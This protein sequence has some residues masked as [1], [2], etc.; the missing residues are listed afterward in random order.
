MD[1]RRIKNLIT[2]VSKPTHKYIAE[3]TFLG[4]EKSGEIVEKELESYSFT[5]YNEEGNTLNYFQKSKNT[6]ISNHKIKENGD[7]NDSNT[8]FLKYSYKYNSKGQIVEENTY[9]SN[10]L[11]IQKSIYEYNVK[12][13]IEECRE[14]DIEGKLISSKRYD[15]KGNIIER[16]IYDR[17]GKLNRKELFKYEFDKNTVEK[18]TYDSE[19]NFKKKEIYK[20]N[21]K[22]NVIEYNSFNLEEMFDWKCITS[23][24]EYDQRNNWIKRIINDGEN[25]K[26]TTRKIVYYGEEENT[27]FPNWD[28]PFFK[29]LKE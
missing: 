17:K 10:G 21:S 7:E 2:S 24:Y 8:N 27:D 1:N 29:D 22:G 19:R 25:Y 12:G 11:L 3:K 20:Y 9:D 16:N 26:V 14:Y 15:S 6:S 28:S 18:N 4:V 23:Q 13:Y 5:L